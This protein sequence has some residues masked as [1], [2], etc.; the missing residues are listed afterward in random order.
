M[1]SL[2][3]YRS[4]KHGARDYYAKAADDVTFYMTMPMHTCG[5]T[6]QRSFSFNAESK[7]G[8]ILASNDAVSVINMMVPTAYSLVYSRG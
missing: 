4:I 2:E 6:P 3:I 5:T 1:T 8:K 7:D